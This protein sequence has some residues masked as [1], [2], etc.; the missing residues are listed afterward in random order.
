MTVETDLETVWTSKEQADDAFVARAA[1]ENVTNTIEQ[2]HQ[3][4]QAIVD[5]GNFNTIPVDLRT[6]LNNW[7][8]VIKTARTSIGG[9]ADIMTIFNWRPTP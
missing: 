5:G 2:T 7:W 1:L 9:D 6:A 8:T 4:I 3:Q